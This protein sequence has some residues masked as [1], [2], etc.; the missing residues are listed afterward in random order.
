M[1]L[2][3]GKSTGF[4][5]VVSGD[6]TQCWDTMTCQHC[7]FVTRVKPFCDPADFGGLCKACCGLICH[8]CVNRR[9]CIP[10]EARITH[11]EGGWIDRAKLEEWERTPVIAIGT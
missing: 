6:G 10:I 9:V 8:N 4:L 11:M 2:R 3:Y 1:S 5:E 7:N